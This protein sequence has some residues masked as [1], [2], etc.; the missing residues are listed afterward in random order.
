MTRTKRK[1][2]E[3]IVTGSNPVPTTI[4]PSRETKRADLTP[5]KE[6]AWRHTAGNGATRNSLTPNPVCT[7][8]LLRKR[9]PVSRLLETG[10]L[11]I[12][13]CKEEDA[14]CIVAEQVRIELEEIERQRKVQ[15]FWFG[16][17]G[18]CGLFDF[19]YSNLHFYRNAFPC[20]IYMRNSS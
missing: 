11:S 9:L 12:W 6:T 1:L 4:F 17:R 19:I 3:A 10:F 20:S 16:P 5:T 13:K 7:N 2:L 18:T 15:G 14:G 8:S